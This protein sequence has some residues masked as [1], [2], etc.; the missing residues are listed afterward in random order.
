MHFTGEE[1]FSAS[2]AARA[3]TLG[4]PVRPLQGVIYARFGASLCASSGHSSRISLRIESRTI[5][6]FAM[7]AVCLPRLLPSAASESF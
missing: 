7:A 4:V 5:T 6:A 3:G 1:R 2:A